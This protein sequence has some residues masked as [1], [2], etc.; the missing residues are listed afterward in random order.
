MTDVLTATYG[1]DISK[2]TNSNLKKKEKVANDQLPTSFVL[3]YVARSSK[4]KWRH[5]KV[6][7]SHDDP[8]QVAS[9]VKTIHNYLASKHQNDYYLYLYFFYFTLF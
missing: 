8:R 2:L 9:W 1:S 3:H 7:M 6:I 5:H 4:N